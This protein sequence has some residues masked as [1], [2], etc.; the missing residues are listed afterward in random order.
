MYYIL[1]EKK[2]EVISNT[3]IFQLLFEKI[4]QKVLKMLFDIMDSCN[5][6]VR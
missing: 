5:I 4:W 1:I 2:V 6:S 3:I